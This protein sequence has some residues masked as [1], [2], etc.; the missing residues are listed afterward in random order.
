MTN[1]RRKQT[2]VG[3]IWRAVNYGQTILCALLHTIKLFISSL[4]YPN[5]G[6]YC[7]QLAGVRYG[8]LIL[9]SHITNGVWSSV[10][11]ARHQVLV[12]VI[13]YTTRTQPPDGAEHTAINTGVNM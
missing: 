13:V 4:V 1:V 3:R 8:P 5:G 10:V 7:G 11:E 12:V 2:N 9:Y 6:N